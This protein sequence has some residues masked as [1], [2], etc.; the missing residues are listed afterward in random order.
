VLVTDILRSAR[1]FGPADLRKLN[2][3]C[4]ALDLA[5]RVRTVSSIA[6]QPDCCQLRCEDELPLFIKA[7]GSEALRRSAPGGM[8]VNTPG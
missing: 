2:Q 3:P 6:R 7:C 8:F 4:E 1:T 5:I